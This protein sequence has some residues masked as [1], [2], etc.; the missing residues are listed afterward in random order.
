MAA[1][2]FG[3]DFDVVGVNGE[4][5][6]SDRLGVFGRYGYSSYPNTTVGDINPNY[7]MVGLAFPDL[8]MEQAIAGIAVGQP[9]IEDRVGDATQTNFELFYNLPVNDHI[10]ITP[11]I[12]VITNPGNQDAN[13]TIFT[14]TVRTIF[15]F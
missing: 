12:Q 11:L 14:G 4:L 15:S 8:L 10:R 6:L 13:G 2:V 7:W 3:S 9:F 5:A 1:V